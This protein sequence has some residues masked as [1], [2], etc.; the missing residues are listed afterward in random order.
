MEKSI[1][2]KVATNWSDGKT[3]V[4]KNKEHLSVKIATPP[5]FNGPS[6]YFSPEELFLASINS[7]IMTTFFYFAE[8]FS[9]SFLSYESEASGEVIFEDG[10]FA[11]SSIIVKPV[12]KVKDT[13]EKEKAAK[14]IEKSEKYC[15]ISNSVKA[16]I[17]VLPE[18]I[19]KE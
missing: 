3:G 15:L 16:D 10:K 18:I 13:T 12:I 9:F 8:R 4:V 1:V 6:G 19:V 2:F 7:C 14:G 17:K 5:E 11:F